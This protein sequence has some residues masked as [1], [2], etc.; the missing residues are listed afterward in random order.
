MKYSTVQLNIIL[1]CIVSQLSS[2][3][4]LIFTYACNQP[5]LIEWQYKGLKKFLLDEDYELILFN[6]ARDVHEAQKI[7][8]M[9]TKLALKEIRIPMEIH[10]NQEYLK[11]EAPFGSPSIQHCRAAQWSLENYGFDHNDILVILDGDLFLCKPFSIREF[12]GKHVLAGFLKTPLYRQNLPFLWIGLIIIDMPHLPNKTTFNICVTTVDTDH[13]DSGGS[14][15]YYLKNNPSV[16]LK[17]INKTNLIHLRCPE[18]QYRL[19]TVC[20][21]NRTI[22]EQK[23]FD[24]LAI[25]FLQKMPSIGFMNMEYY[26]DN[27]FLHFRGGSDYAIFNKP[28]EKHAW[29]QKAQAIEAYLTV[30]TS[31][32]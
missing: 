10:E 6:N 3:K 21:H 24:E 4:I 31:D 30:L 18:C 32:Y 20:T 29:T 7:T 8:D 26:L 27:S 9:C 15:Y 28:R 14:T 22:L 5:Q 1:F 2:A 23:G 16:S 13:L 25:Q 17:C 12:L 19:F 11:N